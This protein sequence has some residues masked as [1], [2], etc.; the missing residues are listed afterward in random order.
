MRRENISFSVWL[1]ADL[2]PVILL[3]RVF[4]ERFSIAIAIWRR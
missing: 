2:H 3:G 4:N 1:C